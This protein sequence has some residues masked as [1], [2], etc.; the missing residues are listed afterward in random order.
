MA[1]Y[2]NEQSN[3]ITELFEFCEDKQVVTLIDI[4]NHLPDIDKETLINVIKTLENMGYN[5][6]MEEDADEVEDNEDT[7]DVKPSSSS[8]PVHLYIKDIGK[9]PLL[10]RQ[11]EVILCEQIEN[12]RH[13]LAEIIFASPNAIEY[14]AE[15]GSA[16]ENGDIAVEHVVDGLATLDE[17]SSISEDMLEN[18]DFDV[19]IQ[20]N[21]CN[22]EMKNEVVNILKNLSPFVEQMKTGLSSSEGENSK[23]YIET[24]KQVKEVLSVIRFTQSTVKK[25]CDVLRSDVCQIREVESK[26]RNLVVDKSKVKMDIFKKAFIGNETSPDWHDS[27]ELSNNIIEEVKSQQKIIIDITNNTGLSVKKIKQMNVVM[28]NADKNF[29]QAKEKMIESN[30]RLVV[31]IAKRFNNR[32]LQFLD[33]IQEGNMGLMKAVD[34]FEHRR[35]FKFSTYATWWIRQSITRA[36]SDQGRTIRVPVYMVDTMQRVNR[37]INNHIQEKGVEPTTQEMSVALG[38]SENKIKTAL[39]AAKNSISLDTTTIGDDDSDTIGDLIADKNTLNPMEVAMLEGDKLAIEK[40]L[41]TLNPREAKVLRLRFGLNQ[42]QTEHTLEEVGNQM[43]LT[44]ERIRQLEVTAISK[45]KKP[46]RVEEISNLMGQDITS[47]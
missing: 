3:K 27:L 43:N 35:G 6:D 4:K 24:A 5:I 16:I 11:E 10:S 7:L 9:N 39:T 17:M 33:L 47:F 23:V 37:F 34:K 12:A 20:T 32:G 2:D 25:L 26:I 1:K 30:L 28:I 40:V 41:S 42:D 8:D 14:L 18:E 31:S 13:K 46:H 38:I 36:I 19:E 21:S 44:R 15:V 22:E 29:Q 45:L